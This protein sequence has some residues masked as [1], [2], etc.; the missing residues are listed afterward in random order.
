MRPRHSECSPS[1]SSMSP[2]SPVSCAHP[3]SSS[4]VRGHSPDA[5]NLPTP[6]HTKMPANGRGGCCR[7]T[8]M[9]LAVAATSP[10]TK[11]PTA[12]SSVLP[13]PRCPRRWAGPSTYFAT[14]SQL[15]S[16]SSMYTT[17]I[18]TISQ[19]DGSNHLRHP[20][21]SGCKRICF[22]CS[23]PRFGGC[24]TVLDVYSLAG[25]G[26]GLSMELGVMKVSLGARAY[27][28]LAPVTVRWCWCCWWCW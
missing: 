24:G 27:V 23:N 19:Q 8:A 5:V 9:A 20:F 6:P 16:K 22:G 28:V 12:T 18:W 13:P 3:R 17:S 26:D 4:S 7:T 15:A 2:A 10:R 14:V 21:S 1:L 25:G 11:L